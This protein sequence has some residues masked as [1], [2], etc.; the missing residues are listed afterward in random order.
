MRALADRFHDH[1]LHLSELIQVV[2][3]RGYDLLLIL[4]AL[5]FLTPIPLPLL[6]VPF[7]VLILIT[8]TRITLG[9]PPSWPRWL[10]DRPLPPKFFGGLLRATGRIVGFIE[11]LVRPRLQFLHSHPVFQRLGGVLIALS[12]LFLLLPLP[13]PMS[14][15]F[16]ALTVILLASGALESD[17]LFFLAGCGAFCASAAYLALIAF[18]GTQIL[19]RLLT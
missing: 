12:G 3:G 6:S 8:G 2:H 16:P 7:G 1:P 19:S 13:V 14:N 18:G 17:G 15:F 10:R 11:W 9:K 4:L 5:P